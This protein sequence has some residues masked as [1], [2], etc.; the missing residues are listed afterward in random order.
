MPENFE[1]FI[2]QNWFK[3]GI[4]AV[5]LIIAFSFLY[6]FV[7]FIPLKEKVKTEQ[8]TQEKDLEQ[9][10]KCAEAGK[11]A[12]ED[13]KQSNPIS[14]GFF[15]EP[16]FYFNKT[17]QQ[18]IYDGGINQVLEHGYWERFIKNSYT[19]ETLASVWQ[20]TKQPSQKEVNAFWDK[21]KELFEK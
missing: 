20:N 18:C 9:Q 6:Y 10:A 14:V 21:H 13:Y 19:N 3:L 5:L 16:Q 7:V 4:L 11:E 12:Y 2:K 8:L 1:E 15:F 17:S